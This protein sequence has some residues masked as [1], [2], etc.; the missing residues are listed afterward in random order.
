MVM[1][2]S[3]RPDFDVIALGGNA[4]LPAGQVGTFDEQVTVTR[5]AMGEIAVL[6]AEGRRVVLTHGNGPIVGNIVIRN[7]A[8][9]DLIAPMPLDVCGGHFHGVRLG[10]MPRPDQAGKPIHV[11]VETFRHIVFVIL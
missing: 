4:I 1:T 11:R 9:R 7:E 8:A 6:L 10:E 5:T 2:G 3:S